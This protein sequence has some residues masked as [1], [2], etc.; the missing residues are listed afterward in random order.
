MRNIFQSFVHRS[1]LQILGRNNT[2][3]TTRIHQVIESDLPRAT[4]FARPLS[5]DCTSRI[6]D[7][8]IGRE[9]PVLVGLEVNGIDFGAVV[10]TGAAFRSVFEYQVVSLGTDDVP[11]VTAR[12]KRVGEIGNFCKGL[13]Q[14]YRFRKKRKERVKLTGCGLSIEFERGTILYE[15]V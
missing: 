6:G 7:T 2:G 12:S 3:T 10:G 8:R 4:V 9:S 15:Q 13:V 5:G 1:I 14:I 11:S